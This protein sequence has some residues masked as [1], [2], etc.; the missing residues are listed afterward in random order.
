MDGQGVGHRQLN[1]NTQDFRRPPT[2]IDRHQFHCRAHACLVCGRARD[3]IGDGTVFFDRQA[4]GEAQV[5]KFAGGFGGLEHV[6]NR[7]GV[8]Q[9]PAGALDAAERRTGI[10]GIDARLEERPPII[11]RNAVER[12]QHVVECVWH[13]LGR[14][15]FAAEELLAEI[16]ERPAALA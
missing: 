4:E 12:A 6:R 2:A 5:G 7:V 1:G 10:G 15:A 11:G 9:P 8:A 16:V 14:A 13:D 3:D